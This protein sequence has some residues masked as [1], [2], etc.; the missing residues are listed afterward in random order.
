MKRLLYS[1]LAISLTASTAMAQ[2]DADYD[3]GEISWGVYP[4]AAQGESFE[5]GVVQHD[6]YDVMH[7]L[8]P[9]SAQDIVA[10]L[11]PI[12]LDSMILTGI[13]FTHT[14]SM[15][16]YQPEE[17][18]LEYA[19]NNNGD[20]PNPCALLGSQQY[21]MAIQ[22][23]PTVP[24]MYQMS[25]EVTGWFSN[26]VEQMSYPTSFDNFS[27]NI[28]C[29]LIE[30]IVT[31]SGNSENDEVGSIDL[32]Y[33]DGLTDVTFEWYNQ[34]NDMIASTED[35]EAAPGTYY[36]IMSGDGCTSLFENIEIGD[37]AYD[38]LLEATYEITNTDEGEMQGVID[39]TVTGANGDANCVWT[40]EDGIVIST[41]EDLEN[42]GFGTY[43]VSIID[44]VG[45]VF[46]LSNLTITLGVED[47][48]AAVVWSMLPNPA[49]DIL[50]I[51][52]PQTGVKNILIRDIQG[53]TIYSSTFSN[54]EKLNVNE[55][56]GGF[57]FVTVSTSHV[58]STRRLVINK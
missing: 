50:T 9:S 1:I 14:E 37:N 40:N 2:C 36:L 30:S 45:C 35:L 11:P 20:L 4:D 21:C 56:D 10:T 24:G 58:Q 44:E 12:P 7:I 47:M 16:E 46:E 48:Q 49:N 3:F 33:I 28:Q 15:V 57:Y 51:S 31:T 38:C 43:S 18:G 6:Y 23:V 26:G 29:N 42:A 39:L 13:T 5:P 34:F 22:G 52:S 25:L 54:S 32:T 17:I 19:C 55:W 41:N 8:V 53:R 27:M